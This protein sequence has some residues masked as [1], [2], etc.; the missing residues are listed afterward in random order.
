VW[1]DK[2]VKLLYSLYAD[3]QDSFKNTS[4]KNNVVWD[5]IKMQM[6]VN[7]YNFTRTQIKDKWMNMRKAYVRVKDH[8]KITGATPKTYR[9]Y[10][11]MDNLYGDKPNVNPVALASNMRTED[12]NTLSS[13]D[14]ATINDNPK[15]KK[16]K[17]ERQLSSWT[18]KFI[19]HHCK[20]RE[21]RNE[22]RQA[23]KI[24]AIENATKTFREMM[25]KL[26]EKL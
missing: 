11:E 8:N 24:I 22:A 13:D 25:E 10:N 20:E 12:E 14:S 1:D 5:K 21:Q 4:V 26:I 3:N 2:A 19:N 23:E 18:E 16:S 7:G 15:R 9:Y 17:I 6:N